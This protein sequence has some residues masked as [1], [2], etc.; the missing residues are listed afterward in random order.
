MS[1]EAGGLIRQAGGLNRSGLLHIEI[2]G[3]LDKL[4][5][6]KLLPLFTTKGPRNFTQLQFKFLSIQTISRIKV[7]WWSWLDGRGY[8]ATYSIDTRDGFI[9]V[10]I[11]LSAVPRVLV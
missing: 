3:N 6:G 2:S 4:Y 8:D 11:G 1:L 9:S 7:I 5:G 10:P